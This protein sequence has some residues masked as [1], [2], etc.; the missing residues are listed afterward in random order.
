VIEQNIDGTVEVLV[1][2]R[3]TLEEGPY[4]FLRVAAI[5]DQN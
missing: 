5:R 4:H 3:D 1:C 2:L